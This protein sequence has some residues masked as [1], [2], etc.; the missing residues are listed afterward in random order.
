M[1]N[2]T[3]EILH[4]DNFGFLALIDPD[5]KNDEILNQLIESINKSKFSAILVGGS[6]IQDDKYEQRLK[7]I[8]EQS[9]KPIILFPG[10]SE[11]ISK[12]AD[13]ILFKGILSLIYV[14]S[15]DSSIP[16]LAMVTV[17]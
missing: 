16:V 2:S 12:Y 9:N 6:S 8:K 1:S 3:L 10:S 11:Q 13:A 7:K 17:T 14:A 15:K 4:K 5:V